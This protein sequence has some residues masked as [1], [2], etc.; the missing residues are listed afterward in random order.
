MHFEGGGSIVVPPYSFSTAKQ[1]DN[2][3]DLPDNGHLASPI[4]LPKVD[5]NT[6][7]VTDTP[8]SFSGPDDILS[9]GLIVS[10]HER[11]FRLQNKHISALISA[12]GAI[13]S[14]ID[15][16][17][18]YCGMNGREL[19]PIG[20]VANNL[21]L[22][23]D[24]PFYWDAWD[25]M[26]YH[27]MKG[28]S[29]NTTPKNISLENSDPIDDGNC[30][31]AGVTATIIGSSLEGYVGIKFE[32]YD[33]G[34]IT[35][36]NIEN[37]SKLTQIIRLDAFSAQLLFD[38][39][40]DWKE[41]R[42]LLKVEF[43]L[44]I[45][46]TFASYEVQYGLVTRPTHKNTPYDEAMFEVCG[47]R[48]ADLSECNY[49]V[50]LLND[51]KYGYSCRGSTL[52]LSLLRSPKAPDKHCDM[53]E[54]HFQYALLPHVG[55]SVYEGGVVKAA[56]LLNSQ[57]FGP[58]AIPKQLSSGIQ[59]VHREYGFLRL[60]PTDCS[61]ILDTVKVA[62]RNNNIILRFYESCG[63]RGIA[64]VDFNGLPKTINRITL[65]NMNEECISDIMISNEAF[66]LQY[67][68]FC[69]ITVEIEMH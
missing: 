12:R 1:K 43:P 9:D 26:P 29:I 51:C 33:W 7:E 64:K 67:K 56:S 62:E 55:G 54:H 68:P 8:E 6:V 16:R 42:K 24:I 11:G 23:E 39:T 52:C 27:T 40:V 20:A 49:G 25:T 61:L 36:E 2:N 44:E 38:T 35:D 59:Y 48:F 46:S 57:L 65:C 50:A 15:K 53:G 13:I 28:T 30:A 22:Y 21:M 60:V 10:R 32:L 18:S 69:V 3:R 17:V 58:Y 66:E 14:L 41:N 5:G 4:S 31:L 34:G 37:K 19:I 63:A 47:H 45:R